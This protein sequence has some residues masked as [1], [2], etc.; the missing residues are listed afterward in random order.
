ME[1]N[2]D[3]LGDVGRRAARL[4]VVES[5]RLATLVEDLMEISRLDAG[6]AP[7][8]WERVDMGAAV[9]AALTARGWDDRVQT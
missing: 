6:M 8:T 5:R 9:A 3:G 4:L 7:M 1:A 2:T